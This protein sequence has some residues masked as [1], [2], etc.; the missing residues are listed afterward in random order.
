MD[1]HSCIFDWSVRDKE[2]REFVH[3][4]PFRASLILA[5]KAERK[6]DQMVG[7]NCPFFWKSSQRVAKPKYIY[8]KAKFEKM[9]KSK[10]F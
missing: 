6:C 10:Q 4:E 3:G 1:K 5:S 8:I 9:S 2:A 7:K